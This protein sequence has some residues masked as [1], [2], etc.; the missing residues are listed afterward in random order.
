M[1]TKVFMTMA[2]L[3]LMATGCNNEDEMDN[4]N[5]EIRLT[6]GIEVQTR[7]THNLDESLKNG[8]T[9]HVWVD[10]AKTPTSSV[11]KENLYENNQLTKIEGGALTSGTTM[12]FPKTG[13]SVNIFALH[14]NA[15][16]ADNTFPVSQLTHTVATN[17]KSTDNNNGY[18]KSDLV[19]AKSTEVVRTSNT[20][21][22]TFNHLLSKVEVILKEGDGATGFL[23]NLNSLKIMNTKPNAQF[24]LTKDG[25]SYGYNTE[26]QDGIAILAGGDVTEISIDKDVT[27]E[28]NNI[29]NEAIIVPQTLAAATPFIQIKLSAGG[30]FTYKLESETN[31]ESGKKYTY[32]ITVNQTGLTVTSSITDWTV[33]GTANGTATMD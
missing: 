11:T 28:T 16:L 19:Y 9:V 13:N 18:A 5:G 24:T 23:T 20:V 32:T 17:Q 10:D 15:T 3:A 14:T 31:F 27:T 22:L 2:A 21:N 30:V 33:G 26:H 1:K 6:S 4:W 25:P 29:L 12:Y 7:A 8:E